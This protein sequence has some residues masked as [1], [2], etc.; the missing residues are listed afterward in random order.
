MFNCGIM[1]PFSVVGPLPATGDFH[2]PMV[3]QKLAN[4]PSRP[5]APDTGRPTSSLLLGLGPT[6]DCRHRRDAVSGWSG[7]H[8]FLPVLPKKT[9]RPTVKHRAEVRPWAIDPPRLSLPPRICRRRGSQRARKGAQQRKHFANQSETKMNR[10]NINSEAIG[11]KQPPTRYQ[12]Q[13]GQSGNPGGRPKGTRNFKSDLRDEL[14]EIISFREGRR[15]VS[16][17]KQRALIKRLVA[18]AIDGDARSTATVMS[19]CA[20]AFGDDDEDRQ[21]EAPEDQEIM[22]AFGKRR[23]KRGATNTATHKNSVSQE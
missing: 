19:F 1:I 3:D 4:Q 17:S 23:A 16:I 21:P 22:H 20:R 15:E 9:A 7:R 13:P 6:L 5:L 14:S 10:K 2:R 12:F 11:D 18:S 8:C